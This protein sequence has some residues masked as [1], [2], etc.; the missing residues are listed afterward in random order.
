[1]KLGRMIRKARKARALTIKETAQRA[2]VSVSHLCRV[3][4]G[5]GA[6]KPSLKLLER[7]AV[8]VGVPTDDLLLAA[9]HVPSD[10]VRWILRTPGAIERVR[11]EMGAA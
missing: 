9:G 1:M 8:V 6:R 11:K 4:R 10:V 3:E 5:D 2:G 7:V